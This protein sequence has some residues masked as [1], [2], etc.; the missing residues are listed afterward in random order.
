M[1]AS[2][3]T[4]NP[5]KLPS[6]SSASS[7]SVTLSRACASERNASVRVLI[8]LTGRPVILEASSTSGVSLNTGVFM[9][10]LPPM[11]PV[12]TRTLLSGTFNMRATSERK[13]C[14][15]WIGEWMV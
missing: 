5:K 10:K 11:S 6:L 2:V 13:P 1:A 15:R 7:A 12:V 14:A 4:R 3:V 8:H 9:P